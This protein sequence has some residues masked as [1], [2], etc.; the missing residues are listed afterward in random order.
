MDSFWPDG[1]VFDTKHLT[2][3]EVLC[4][5]QHTHTAKGR[6]RTMS[7]QTIDLGKAIAALRRSRARA[8]LAQAQIQAASSEVEL[9]AAVEGLMPIGTRPGS[10]VLI[11]PADLEAPSI[12]LIIDG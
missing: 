7:D 1:M 12:T 3:S 5:G 11:A 2:G 10:R 9:L 8:R 4:A 6:C